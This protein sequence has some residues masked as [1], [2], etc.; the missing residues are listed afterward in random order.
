M[1][2]S[3]KTNRPAPVIAA[4]GPCGVTVVAPRK[5]GAV[6]GEA[7]TQCDC[8]AAQDAVVKIRHSAPHCDLALSCRVEG[9]FS[10]LPG[11]LP[12]QEDLSNHFAFGGW[13]EWRPDAGAYIKYN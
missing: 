3:P 2:Y 8:D 11:D 12:E 4:M 7:S 6:P 5:P 10:V 1:A 13:D 9:G